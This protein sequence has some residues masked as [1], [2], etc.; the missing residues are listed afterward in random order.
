MTRHNQGLMRQLSSTEV[1]TQESVVLTIRAVHQASVSE[2]GMLSQKLGCLWG[3]GE[4]EPG[5]SQVW[6]D[7][8]GHSMY[9][10]GWTMVA[11]GHVFLD[12]ASAGLWPGTIWV[13]RTDFENT[14]ALLSSVEL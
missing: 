11:L 5:L 9:L 7:S 12:R 3:T 4:R 1:W 13:D 14:S 2:K 10:F 6:L 8:T